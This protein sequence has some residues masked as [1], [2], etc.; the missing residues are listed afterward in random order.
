LAGDEDV[1]GLQRAAVGD[2]KRAVL[3][4]DIAADGE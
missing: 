3:D 2:G 1:G 4:L